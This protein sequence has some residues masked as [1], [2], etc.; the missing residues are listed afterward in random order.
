MSDFALALTSL[1]RQRDNILNTALLLIQQTEQTDQAERFWA[2]ILS[3]LGIEI[4]IHLKNLLKMEDFDNPLSLRNLSMD[5]IENLEHFGKTHMLK[6]LE[7]SHNRKDYFGSYYNTPEQFR[8][9]SGNKKLL[10]ELSNY[11]KEKPLNYFSKYKLFSN[12]EPKLLIKGKKRNDASLKTGLHL[13]RKHG[14]SENNV[15]AMDDSQGKKNKAGADCQISLEEE[16][17]KGL[18]LNWIKKSIDDESQLA[19]KLTAFTVIVD[20]LASVH[21]QEIVQFIGHIQCPICD[22]TIKMS[23][24]T[25]KNGNRSWVISNFPRHLKIAHLKLSTSDFDGKKPSQSQTSLKTH[26][27]LADKIVVQDR[28][29]KSV[30]SSSKSTEKPCT[31]VTTEISTEIIEEITL[32]PDQINDQNNANETIGFDLTHRREQEINQTS[33]PINSGEDCNGAD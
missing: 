20:Q 2:I 19:G 18:L 30:P 1:A 5:D 26:F 13:K 7:P 4:P 15:S 29:S 10:M 25:R 6:L 31:S 21:G 17:L 28:K 9:S 32:S 14:D 11:I 8:I 12:G 16:K 33:R 23:T 3:D 24:T 22:C 27:S